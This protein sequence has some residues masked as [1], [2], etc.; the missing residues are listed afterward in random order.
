MSQRNLATEEEAKR[1]VKFNY[2]EVKDLT[3]HAS[4]VMSGVLVFAL[5]FGEKI[6][7]PESPRWSQMC[8]GVA[9][10]LFLLGLIFAGRSS[11]L[12]Y[13]A[14][15]KANGPVV[16]SVS[17]RTSAILDRVH[18]MPSHGER[19]RTY[20]EFYCWL[21]QRCQS[22]SRKYREGGASTGR[23]GRQAAVVDM[24]RRRLTRR[25]TV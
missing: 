12:I 7:G 4:T 3:K 11:Y 25:Q 20:S 1:F 24:T 22:T 15:E 2:P 5:T 10:F 17:S 21:S 14:G 18:T 16:F 19:S 6:V 9:L 13:M 23:A 8:F